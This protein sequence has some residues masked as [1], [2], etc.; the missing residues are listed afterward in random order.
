MH[1]E[2]WN[3]KNLI[4]HVKKKYI[5]SAKTKMSLVQIE[6]FLTVV[7]TNFTTRTVVIIQYLSVFVSCIVNKN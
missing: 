7:I 3:Y 2:L 1:E 4:M 6:Y 5:Y